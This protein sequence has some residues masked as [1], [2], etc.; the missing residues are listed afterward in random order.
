MSKE[1]MREQRDLRMQAAIAK[2]QRTEQSA[3]FLRTAVMHDASSLAGEQEHRIG[4]PNEQKSDANAACGA[5]GF[6]INKP[7]SYFRER[8]RVRL[9]FTLSAEIS[10]LSMASVRL[11]AASAKSAGISTIS[12][13]ACTASTALSP[14]P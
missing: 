11:S 3:F 14:A 7:L 10:P 8:M 5:I 4:K 12:T 6:Y 13:P 9:S 1:A 2:V